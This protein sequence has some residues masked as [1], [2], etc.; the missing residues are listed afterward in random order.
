MEQ[1]QRAPCSLSPLQPAAR[2]AGLS[3]GPPSL[4][5]SVTSTTGSPVELTVPRGETVEGLRTR[6]SQRLRLRTDRIALL[7]RDRHLTAGKLLEHSVTDGSRLTL[8]PVVEAGLVCSSARAERTTMDVLESLTDAQIAD[9]L[10]G[11]S[12]LTVSLRVGSHM[13]YV[14]LQLSAQDVTELQR[15]GDSWPPKSP[16]ESRSTDRTP[17]VCVDPQGPRTPPT[18]APAAAPAATCPSP[19]H[20]LISTPSLP[21]GCPSAA[22]PRPAAAPLRWPGAGSPSPGPP[23]P[24]AASTVTEG[25]SAEPAPPPGAVIQSFVSHSP[26]V[27]SGTFS[28]TLAPCSPSSAPHPRRGVSIILQILNDLLRAACSHQGAPPALSPRLPPA[29]C[30]PRPEQRAQRPGGAPPPSEENRTLQRKLQRLRRLLRQR[31]LRKRTGGT[32]SQRSRPYQHRH[33]SP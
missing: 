21:P 5:L 28:G 32:L 8:V 19:P 10:S 18:R 1:Q 22:S 24:A 3:S 12:P 7:H 23:S 14:Q 6:I 9:F 4:R 26:G 27:F 15:V 29:A 31:R 17:P 16:A 2:G 30:G 25:G 13:M 33:H 11:R 20:T